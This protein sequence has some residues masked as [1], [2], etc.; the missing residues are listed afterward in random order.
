MTM[1]Q[2]TCSHCIHG[3]IRVQ[4]PGS[5]HLTACPKCGG[6]AYRWLPHGMT[7]GDYDAALSGDGDAVESIVD[8]LTV[9]TC[10]GLR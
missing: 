4:R 2:V 6:K 8:G 7:E 1:T 10:G 9:D 3:K 5:I